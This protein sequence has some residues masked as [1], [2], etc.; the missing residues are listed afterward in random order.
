MQQT[1][2][3][4]PDAPATPPNPLRSAVVPLLGAVT[5]HK[6]GK[7]PP[8]SLPAMLHTNNALAPIHTHKPY[9]EF[10]LSSQPPLHALIASTPTLSLHHFIQSQAI[11]VPPAA[12][13]FYRHLHAH[14]IPYTLKVASVATPSPLRLH[15]DARTAQSLTSQ[16]RFRNPAERPAMLVALGPLHLLFAFR[17]AARIAAELRRSPELVTAV[18]AST[19]DNFMRRADAGAASPQLIKQLV[20]ALLTDPVRTADCVASAATRLAHAPPEVMSE[21][22]TCFVALQREFP[23]DAMCFAAYLLNLL[24]LADGNAVFVHE[25]E[26]YCVLSGD[27]VEAATESDATVVGGLTHEE[28]VGSPNIFAHCL[29]YDDSPVEISH[30]ERV[31]ECTVS[32]VPPVSHFQLLRF[33]LP[34]GISQKMVQTIAPSVILVLDG[35]G[36][37][38]VDSESTL[39]P[40]RAGS[41]YYLSPQTSLLVSSTK[42]SLTPLHFFQIGVNESAAPSSSSSCSIM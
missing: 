14:G 17:P 11:H 22:D 2:Q 4:D 21:C 29:S 9:S 37:I 33:T 12:V 8:S 24:E 16:L 41:L 3:P 18:G 20:S 5:H 26:P 30:G 6:W 10:I 7:H 28:D 34:G 32:Y 25:N 1:H 40:L 38:A 15:P 42:H 31:S 35:T 39:M 36:Y 19:A 27:F 23:H 13:H